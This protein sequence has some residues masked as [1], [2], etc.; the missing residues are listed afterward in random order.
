MPNVILS[1]A[2]VLAI[3]AAMLF[4]LIVFPIWALIHCASAREVG[5]RG[6]A[7][8]V[9]LILLFWTVG[10]ALYGFFAS[11][12]R[13][14][15][16]ISATA[17]AFSVLFVIVL[18]AAYSS[19]MTA[20]PRLIR[21]K[22]DSMEQVD[23]MELAAGDRE[24]VKEDLTTLLNEFEA[25]AWFDVDAKQRGMRLCEY[26]ALMVRDGKLDPAEYEKWRHLFESRRLLDLSALENAVNE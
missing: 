3:V 2:L 24:R 18:G 22:I 9:V 6:K 11:G 21:Q 7:F 12:K 14:F 20:T 8:W 17:L 16:W 13:Y 1:I 26:F 5:G 15:K 10:G 19:M 4:Y 23:M 25:A